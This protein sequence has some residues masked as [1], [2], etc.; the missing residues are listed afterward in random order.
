MV[1]PEYLSFL[2]A[3]RNIK[4]SRAISGM[5]Y[6]GTSMKVIFAGINMKKI[7]C[8]FTRMLKQMEQIEKRVLPEKVL[9]FCKE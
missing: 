6:Y 7:F 4:S 9:P 5:C 2:M 1:A 3:K 8:A